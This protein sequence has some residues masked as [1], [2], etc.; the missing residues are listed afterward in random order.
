[1]HQGHKWRFGISNTC[2]RWEGPARAGVRRLRTH[3]WSVVVRIIGGLFV[4]LFSYIGWL[5]GNQTVGQ[6]VTNQLLESF[7]LSMLSK[8]RVAIF[9]SLCL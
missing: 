9:S 1:M 2:S 8:I 6:A 3:V 5:V 7:F 4:Y